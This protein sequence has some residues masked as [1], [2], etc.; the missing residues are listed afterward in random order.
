MKLIRALIDIM[1]CKKADNKSFRNIGNDINRL[2]TKVSLFDIKC[3][4]IWTKNGND[5]FEFHI[6]TSIKLLH[7]PL[8]PL[9]SVVQK[10]ELFL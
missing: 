4:K 10:Y 8:A 7:T 5:I 3:V 6:L 9:L 1:V 2:E